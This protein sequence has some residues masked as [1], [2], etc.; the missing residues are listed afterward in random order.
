MAKSSKMIEIVCPKCK[1]T[2]IINL[3]KEKMPKC[4]ACAVRM[5]VKEVLREGKA[6]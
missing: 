4:E 3:E 6:F 1:R 5:V 2:Q